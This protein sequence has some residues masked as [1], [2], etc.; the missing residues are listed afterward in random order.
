MHECDVETLWNRFLSEGLGLTV[1]H[2]LDYVHLCSVIPY[3]FY[4]LLVWSQTFKTR[5][6]VCPNLLSFFDVFSGSLPEFLPVFV[7]GCFE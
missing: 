6:P 5:C 7:E 1:R 4:R 3:K 2:A